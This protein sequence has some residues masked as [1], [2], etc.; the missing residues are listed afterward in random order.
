M[1]LSPIINDQNTDIKSITHSLT[2]LSEALLTK[3]TEIETKKCVLS[4]LQNDQ[5]HLLSKISN[6]ATHLSHLNDRCLHCKTGKTGRSKC[7]SLNNQ[8]LFHQSHLSN[9]NDNVQKIVER[10]DTLSAA[11]SELELNIYTIKK[12]QQKNFK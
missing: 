9:L 2:F 8:V 3:Q 7:R 10:I 1:M 5:K 11:I 6:A 12:F 4:K